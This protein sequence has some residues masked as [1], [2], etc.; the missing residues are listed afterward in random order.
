[1][2]LEQKDIYKIIDDFV[3]MKK[4]K[5]RKDVLGIF[6]YG[7]SLYGKNNENSDIDLHVITSGKADIRGNFV[8]GNTHVEYFERPYSKILKQLKHEKQT[9]Q[10]VLLSML[11]YGKIIY[12]KANKLTKLQEH[13]KKYYKDYSPQPLISETKAIYDAY[14]IYINISRLEKLSN[15]NDSSFHFMYYI[16]LN[17]IKQ[18]HE[19]FVGLSTDISQY[20]LKRFYL[21]NEEQ[22]NTF[23]TIP[24]EKF[25]NLFLTCV[26]C[27]ETK[28][29]VVA[30]KKLFSCCTSCLNFDFDGDNIILE[31]K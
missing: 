14:K 20:K 15:E 23:K 28:E 21:K 13:I 16:V 10:T 2:K 18:L 5:T 31:R 25:I 8:M 22:T 9:N 7:S 17:N 26:E 24:D 11:G 3:D 19:K 12:E 1:M 6:F 30:I 27:K 4:Y 29:M